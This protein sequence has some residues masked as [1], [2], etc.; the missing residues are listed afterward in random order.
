M[1]KTFH[2][3]ES[4]SISIVSKSWQRGK[5][6]TNVAILLV[7]SNCDIYK[8]LT[9]YSYIA[10]MHLCLKYI[11]IWHFFKKVRKC[12]WWSSKHF[13]ARYIIN[14]ESFSIYIS[15][16]VNYMCMHMYNIQCNIHFHAWTWKSYKIPWE[17]GL[18][19]R[20][21]ELLTSNRLPWL[22]VM[23]LLFQI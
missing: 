4:N 23:D 7:W 13:K 2:Y 19:G 9:R 1:N 20:H 8:K 18:Y 21:Q 12:H 10:Y 22:L 16:S 5:L 3:Y 11:N 14:K 15:H 6:N 17:I